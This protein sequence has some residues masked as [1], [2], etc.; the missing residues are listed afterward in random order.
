M[1]QKA[2]GDRKRHLVTQ[3][4]Q[5]LPSVISELE[6]EESV[7]STAGKASLGDETKFM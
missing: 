7:L 2:V 5:T 6:I 1:Q 3:D 4:H